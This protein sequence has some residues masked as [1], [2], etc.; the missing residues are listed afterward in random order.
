MQWDYLE[1][2]CRKG[3]TYSVPRK[4]RRHKNDTTTFQPG[5]SKSLFHRMK[6]PF[7]E[8]FGQGIETQ[9]YD[10]HIHDARFTIDATSGQQLMTITKKGV[11]KADKGYLR[12]SAA[13]EMKGPPPK[14]IMSM[15]QCIHPWQSMCQGVPVRLTQQYAL[16]RGICAEDDP[17][18]GQQSDPQMLWVLHGY[19]HIDPSEAGG[20]PPSVVRLESLPGHVGN[21]FYPQGAYLINAFPKMTAA[22]S[23]FSREKMFPVK[24]I[25]KK[26][27]TAFELR[28]G[29]E[30]HFTETRQHAFSLVELEFQPV[31][32]EVEFEYMLRDAIVSKFF[33]R[34]QAAIHFIVEEHVPQFVAHITNRM[35]SA[36]IHVFPDTTF[37][38]DVVQIF[39]EEGDVACVHN[40]QFLIGDVSVFTKELHPRKC[41]IISKVTT[42]YHRTHLINGTRFDEKA[43]A[44][45]V[46]LRT[47][48]PINK[49]KYEK[50]QRR[51]R[52]KISYYNIDSVQQA[53]HNVSIYTL[54]NHFNYIPPFGFQMS[55]QFA[56]DV[57]HFFQKEFP[58]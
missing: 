55:E 28:P 8:H 9:V 38:K 50:E 37:G 41:R 7:D 19:P 30:M 25:R 22:V 46:D 45:M 17:L 4:K 1:I 53:A 35:P 34:T 33:P 11:G 43:D 18:L 40:P 24:N 56:R 31:V 42:L 20:R 52:K 47:M 5:I 27:R 16:E 58:L 13:L 36:H 21:H 10:V 48:K 15:F 54:K 57:K 12:L 44:K 49:K 6:K 32:Y 26:K 14:N 51:K 2:E 3:M 23:P 39:M 29:I